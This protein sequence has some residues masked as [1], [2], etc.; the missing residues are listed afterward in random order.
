MPEEPAAR[1]RLDFLDAARGLAALMVLIEHGLHACVPGYLDFSKANFVIGQSAILVFFMV[2]GF[3]IPMS[4]EA[5][6]SQAGFWLRRSCR[7]FPI[8][9]LS[10]ALA[11]ALLCVG[12]GPLPVRLTD[13]KTW[14]ANLV[15]LQELLKLPHVWG[16]FWTLPFEVLI[17][18][19]CALLFAC[20]LL[21][22]IGARTCFALI[23]GFGLLSVAR[24]LLSGKP[25]PVDGMRNVVFACTLFG[26][27]AHR[28]VEGR[29][30]RR[31]L[32]GLL[33]AMAGA[34]L[35]GWGVNHALF[36]SEVRFGHLGRIA[37]I[38]GLAFGFFV[39]LLE[40]RRRPMPKLACWLGRRSYPIYLLHPF[41]LTFVPTSLP[42]WAFMPCLLAGALLLA[43]LAH[44]LVELPGIALGR[45]IEK[46]FK[47]AARETA[48]PVE[49]RRRAA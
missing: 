45:R 27:I 37:L 39:F 22:R 8:Y 48:A 40:A 17:Y 32:Y 24:P 7:L 25:I 14:L 15:L 21:D 31:S 46:R 23:A 33:A 4:L 42:A 5:G 26:L 2:S 18:I 3:V 19:V 44:R 35:L 11:F 13:T 47:P 1:D 49:M 29:I 34:V 9:W 12:G 30:G 36:P 43:A 6:G 20:R 41:V 38:W 10:I 16:V 28:Y